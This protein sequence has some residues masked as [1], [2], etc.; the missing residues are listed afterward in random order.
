MMIGQQ[1]QQ[2]GG[3]ATGGNSIFSDCP[4][5][6]CGRTM[7]TCASTDE[8][9]ELHTTLYDIGAHDLMDVWDAMDVEVCSQPCHSH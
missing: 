9:E 5:L 4:Q 7:S 6:F 1:Q 8:L 3:G 2:S